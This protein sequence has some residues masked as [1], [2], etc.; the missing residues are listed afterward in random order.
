MA[1]AVVVFERDDSVAVVPTDWMAGET[2]CAWPD[3][4][5]L[6]LIERAVRDREPRQ[7][8]WPAYAVEIK[9][10]SGNLGIVQRF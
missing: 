1:Y 10:E 7:D 2:T 9:Y 5:N 6:K 8:E 4:K 3:M